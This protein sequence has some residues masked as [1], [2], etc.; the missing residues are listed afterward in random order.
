M[1]RQKGFN[2]QKKAFTTQKKNKTHKKKNFKAKH[3]KKFFLC[4]MF[5]SFFFNRV[6]PY[7]FFF[8]CPVL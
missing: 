1:Y 8:V 3:Q 6:P 5:L 4:V 2:A 7:H